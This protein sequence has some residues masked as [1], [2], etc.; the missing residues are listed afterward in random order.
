M[1]VIFKNK[2]I[3]G[4]DLKNE[5]NSFNIENDLINNYQKIYSTY[6]SDNSKIFYQVS[7]LLMKN[8][9]EKTNI[10]RLG[11]YDRTEQSINR[12][13]LYSKI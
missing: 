8:S 1:S 7:E 4:I 11:R 5:N 6:S 12:S 3:N 9:F 13:Y 2:S 10:F